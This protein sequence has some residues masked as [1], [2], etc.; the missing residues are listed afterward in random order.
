VTVLRHAYHAQTSGVCALA[1]QRDLFVTFV[2]TA[3][4]TATHAATRAVIVNVDV[5]C[6]GGGSG[7]MHNGGR[8]GLVIMHFLAVPCAAKHQCPRRK[9]CGH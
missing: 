5:N 1:R 9:L 3:A 2:A 4:A 7:N 8:T 6:G